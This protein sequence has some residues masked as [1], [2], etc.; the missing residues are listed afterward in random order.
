M[1]VADPQMPP[2]T[3]A[4]LKEDDVLFIRDTVKG[5][6]GSAAIIRNYGTD[7]NALRIHIETDQD[8]KLEKYDC[9]GVLMTKLNVSHLEVTRKGRRV[10]GEAKIA[11]RQGVVL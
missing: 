9:L 11:Y 7:A 5:F 4:L 3:P 6:F 10:R 8:L 2:E 1:P